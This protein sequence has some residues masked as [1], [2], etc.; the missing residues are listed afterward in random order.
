MG[1]LPVPYAQSKGGR[2]IPLRQRNP[3]SVGGDGHR[4]VAALL[5]AIV[6]F[7]LVAAGL[8]RPKQPASLTQTGMAWPRWGSWTKDGHLGLSRPVTMI[9]AR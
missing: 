6:G 8:G 7:R 1:I 2:Q 3:P 5:R 4:K 9:I